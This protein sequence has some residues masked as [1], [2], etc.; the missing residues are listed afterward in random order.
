[1]IEIPPVIDIDVL[2]VPIAGVNPAGADLRYEPAYDKIKI[3]RRSVEEQAD[4]STVWKQIITLTS[5][6]LKAQSKDLRVAVWLLEALTQTEGFIGARDG[7]IVLR[8]LLDEFWDGVFPV[9]DDEDPEPL[10]FRMSVIEWV[11]DKLPGLLKALPLTDRSENYSLVHYEATQVADATKKAALLETGW[12]TFEAFATVMSGSSP[13]WLRAALD[14]ITACKAAVDDLEA[15]CDARLVV[16]GRPVIGFTTLREALD[17]GR[18]VVEQALKKH[19]RA[20]VVSAAGGEDHAAAE[21]GGATPDAATGAVV[22]AGTPAD[23]D[24]A[25]KQLARVASFLRTDNPYHPLAYLIARAVSTG[26]LFA[27][28]SAAEAQPLPAPPPGARQRLK[29]LFTQE[30]WNDL[31][32]E[33]EALLEANEKI[34]W[35]E[36]Y[37][38]GLI[39]MEQMGEGYARAAAVA[40]DHL[41]AL[42]SQLPDL[43][44]AELEDGTPVASQDTLRWLREHMG[45]ADAGLQAEPPSRPPVPDE[46]ESAPADGAAPQG[47]DG[48]DLVRSGR[49]AEGLKS[50]Q[51]WVADAQSGRERFVRRLR[52][53]ETCADAGGFRLALPILEELVTTIDQLS[54]DKWEDSS[55]VARVWTA[56]LQCARHL[57]GESGGPGERAKEIFARLCRLDISQAMSLDHNAA[58]AATHWFRR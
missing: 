42:L 7:L 39:A 6:V 18:W 58:S 55:L 45:A 15:V 11:S 25:L 52:L 21:A 29:E 26:Q 57:E 13:D 19:P 28:A 32:V 40:R 50:L 35:L 22:A 36:P 4:P 48:F 2:L 5:Q 46:V 17:N 33:A 47:P 43:P 34:A 12:P 27:H 16:K 30:N 49:M 51:Q 44:E 10:S 24:V 37:R 9:I 8:R 31:L 1:M 41:R 20:G 53:A 54:L 3:A 23:R 56:F 38:Y 14:E